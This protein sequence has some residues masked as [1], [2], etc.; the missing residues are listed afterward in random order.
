[1]GRTEAEQ[2]LAGEIPGTFLF[3]FGRPAGSLV[4]SVKGR[5]G[6]VQHTCYSFKTIMYVSLEVRH[7]EKKPTVNCLG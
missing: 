7:G 1:M 2:V 6:R 3:R 4:L 5:E